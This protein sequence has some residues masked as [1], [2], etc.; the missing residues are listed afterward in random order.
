M[1]LILF[2]YISL[3][4][5]YSEIPQTCRTTLVYFHTFTEKSNYENFMY[6]SNSDSV[7]YLVKINYTRVMERCYLLHGR[8]P[9]PSGRRR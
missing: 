6:F 8:D 2:F 1:M 3:I 5:S 9:W 4:F 7:N